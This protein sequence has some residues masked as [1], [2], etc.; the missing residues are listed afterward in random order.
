MYLT[1]TKRNKTMTTQE[2]TLIITLFGLILSVG[3][4]LFIK[5]TDPYDTPKQTNRE[6]YFKNPSH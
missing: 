5:L 4:P 3:I 6:L 2:T 1:L